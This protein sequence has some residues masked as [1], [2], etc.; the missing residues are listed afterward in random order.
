MIKKQIIVLMKLKKQL[1]NNFLLFSFKF[2]IK[3]HK[4]HLEIYKSQVSASKYKLIVHYL[5]YKV[6]DI[7]VDKYKE[8]VVEDIVKM[9]MDK[10]KNGVEKAILFCYMYNDTM[11]ISEEDNNYL[12]SRIESNADIK[13]MEILI[14]SSKVP[15]EIKNE[16]LD[17][18]KLHPLLV[19]EYK[20]ENKEKNEYS[21]SLYGTN[22]MI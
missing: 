20:K 12:I 3:G 8:N 6:I 14:S 4:F 11:L 16:L 2:N 7:F 21:Y 18:E 15:Y 17:W 9:N 22:L 19:E 13:T 10:I 5:S 1:K